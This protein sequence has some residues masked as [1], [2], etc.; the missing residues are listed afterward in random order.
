[1][2]M[3][4]LYKM[5]RYVLVGAFVFLLQFFTL[6]IFVEVRIL[7]P[8]IASVVAFVVALVSSFFLQRRVTFQKFGSDRIGREF[9]LTAT[10]SLFNLGFNT[11][12][13][14]LLLDKGTH[15][16]VAQAITTTVIVSYTYVAY[17]LIFRV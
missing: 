4:Q 14:Y 1:M 8:L 16:M 9:L 15:Y 10:L 2:M 5:T 3:S 17:H 13:M 7:E 11:A 6:A 12:V